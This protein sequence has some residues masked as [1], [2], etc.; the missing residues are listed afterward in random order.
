L[1]QAINPTIKAKLIKQQHIFL[2]FMIADFLF[3]HELI[4]M[5]YWAKFNIA[6]SGEFYTA[7]P[8]RGQ[9]FSKISCASAE[10][11]LGG[12][13]PCGA[14]NLSQ[15]HLN[16]F[17]VSDLWYKAFDNKYE[18]YGMKHFSMLIRLD[19]AEV[20]GWADT[21]YETTFNQSLAKAQSSQRKALKILIILAPWRL[22]EKI[23]S[24]FYDQTGCPLVGGRARVKL[25]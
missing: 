17:K 6:V 8:Q 5:P 1:P 4:R 9:S 23:I 11:P 12:S 14:A 2:M 20:S 22:C 10:T 18:V 3:L 7:F 25:H 16:G 24:F 13:V 19:A 15:S 21:L